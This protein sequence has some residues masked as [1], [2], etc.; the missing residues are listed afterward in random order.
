M[1]EASRFEIEI[2]IEEEKKKGKKK[3]GKNNSGSKTFAI[4]VVR[5]AV[6]R[7]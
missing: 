5:W 2:E 1:M 3:G 7:Y 4:F 6:C